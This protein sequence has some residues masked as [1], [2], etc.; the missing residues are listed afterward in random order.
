V[1]LKEVKET[2]LILSKQMVELKAA[3]HQRE[4][5]ASRSSEAQKIHWGVFQAQRS[6]LELVES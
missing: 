5:I 2:V 1:S 3:M 6:S 4:E